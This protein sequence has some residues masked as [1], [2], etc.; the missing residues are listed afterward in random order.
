MEHLTIYQLFTETFPKPVIRYLLACLYR[1]R[2]VCMYNNSNISLF[3]II[4]YYIS[5]LYII[6]PDVYYNSGVIHHI[7]GVIS[8]YKILG[9]YQLQLDS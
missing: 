6:A 8:Y 9:F 4:T 1:I 3:G 7:S 5:D 2:S